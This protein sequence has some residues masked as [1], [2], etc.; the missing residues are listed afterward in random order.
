V[1]AA[2]SVLARHDPEEEFEFGLA[3]LLAGLG[4][5]P[6]KRLRRR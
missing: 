3:A 2:A 5:E 6:E 1:R 4:L